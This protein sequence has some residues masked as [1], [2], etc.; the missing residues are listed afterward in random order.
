MHK[1]II[2]KI[3]YGEKEGNLLHV[4]QV[5]SG[6]NCNCVC[7]ECK[8]PLIARKGEKTK[9]HFA[10]YKVANCNNETVLHQIG[11]RLLYKRIDDAIKYSGKLMMIWDCSVCDSKHEGNLI[12]L[13]KSVVLERQLFNCRPDLTL[14]NDKGIP[15]VI[16]EIIVSHKPDENVYEMASEY[17]MPII[18]L[19][20]KN[21]EDLVELNEAEKIQV[22]INDLCV[23]ELCKVCKR[24]KYKK[25]LHIINGECWKCL[26]EMKMA[27]ISY[28]KNYFKG[29]ESFSKFER[30]L[31]IQNGAILKEHYSRTAHEK[32]LANTCSR[33][34]R[35]SG[36]FYHHRYF[37]I[38]Y[39]DEG[40]P[41]DFGCIE[42]LT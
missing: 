21:D 31:S 4:S 24:P 27:F 15:I 25:Y 8:S 41:L 34:G 23:R 1:E 17:S 22:N 39:D 16:I 38:L 3:P 20:I 11:K 2:S 14:L 5:V 42:C 12:K 36:A 10:H 18:E 19:I 7:P 26:G 6:L 9:H 32:Y 37:H 33:C 28:E 35:F 30:E 40:K 29:P 13:A